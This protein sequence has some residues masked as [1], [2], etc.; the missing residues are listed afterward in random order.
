MKVFKIIIE[1]TITGTFEVFAETPE[2]ALAFGI[3]KYKNGEFVLEPGEVQHRQIAVVND[4]K[5][6]KWSEF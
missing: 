6:Q 4:Y 3:E 2:Q 1:E 5:K